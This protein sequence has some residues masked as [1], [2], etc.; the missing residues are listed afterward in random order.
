MI[1]I[2]VTIVDIAKIRAVELRRTYTKAD[3]ATTDLTKGEARSRP[4]RICTITKVFVLISI[5]NKPK[6]DRE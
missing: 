4:R 1:K 2:R 6:S 5:I 3:I